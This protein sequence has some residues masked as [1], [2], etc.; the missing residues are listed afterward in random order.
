VLDERDSE[1]EG[2]IAMLNERLLTAVGSP[3]EWRRG[4][5]ELKRNLVYNSFGAWAEKEF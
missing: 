3:M 1:R 4:S 5:D 2:L